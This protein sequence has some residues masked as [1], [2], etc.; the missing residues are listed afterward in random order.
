MNIKPMGDNVE[1]FAHVMYDDV[2]NIALRV[3]DSHLEVTL[4]IDLDR[5]GAE[6]LLSELTEFIKRDK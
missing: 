4:D 1:L 5:E 2:F 6:R 3:R